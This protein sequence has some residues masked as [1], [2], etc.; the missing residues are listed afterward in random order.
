M[1]SNLDHISGNKKH[2]KDGNQSLNNN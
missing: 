2:I 1:N